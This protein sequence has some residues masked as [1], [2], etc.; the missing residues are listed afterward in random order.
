MLKSLYMRHPAY[1]R[2][3]RFLHSSPREATL[4]LL[5][6]LGQLMRQPQR[7]AWLGLWSVVI[8]ILYDRMSIIIHRIANQSYY[9][10]GLPIDGAFQLLDP[11]RRMAAGQVPGVDFQFFHGL[12]TLMIHYPLFQLFGGNLHASELS[13]EIISP[14]LFVVTAVVLVYV[15]TR[16]WLPALLGLV[17]L[18]LAYPF[19]SNLVVSSNSLL[20]VRTST[21]LL[22]GAAIMLLYQT[23]QRPRLHLA[24]KLLTQ[25]LLAAAFFM[26]IEHGVAAIV[27]YA[28]CLMLFGDG[29][30]WLRLVRAGRDLVIIAVW[31]AAIF[32]LVSGRHWFDPIKF[33]VVELPADQF[34]YF[35]APPN[36]FIFSRLALLNDRW[37]MTLW[38][39][40]GALIILLS[41]YRLSRIRSQAFG[42]IFL[43]MYG[44]IVSVA[45][46]G[47][48]NPAYIQPLLRVVMLALVAFG[49]LWYEH[50]LDR[51][52]RYF[53]LPV[54]GVSVLLLLLNIA[55]PDDLLAQPNPVDY[56]TTTTSGMKLSDKWE[57]YVD[58]LHSAV[59]AGASLWSTYVSLPEAEAG[60][61]NPSGYDY[62]IHALGPTRRAEYSQRFIANPPQFVQT[63]RHDFTRYEEWL[64]MEHWDW[65][66]WVLANYRFKA[67]SPHSVVWERSTEGALVNPNDQPWLATVDR[68]GQEMSLDALPADLPDGTI[69]T[70]E[71]EYHAY[72]L[73][74]KI[75]LVNRLPRYLVAA[76]AS[77]NDIPASLPAYRTAW[78]FPV[79]T[80]DGHIP[81]LKFY[82]ASVAPGGRFEVKHV[83]YRVM[84]LDDTNR[85]AILSRQ[86]AVLA[87]EELPFTQGL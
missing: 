26:G 24:I 34:W 17:V 60:T 79:V 1:S 64:Q 21:P 6:A 9:F 19:V 76:H 48:E 31:A 39:I 41:R 49:F 72:S 13:R 80:K 87:G 25:L 82:V 8:F 15:A 27:S 37:L 28:L 58:T 55:P 23:Y 66:Q 47:I 85:D 16:R 61:F 32:M 14:L 2:L 43:I 18:L 70:V 40:G 78:Q 65:Y 62:I 84:N 83:R 54:A 59:P 46:L 63:I 57:H 10:D 20:G 50:R 45:M 53:A 12:G 30:W 71:V 86:P 73:F 42:F 11:L 3:S 74:E 69:V 67:I 51:G 81:N 77:A 4:S 33:A 7:L 36:N 38:L 44:L 22:V 35:G 52:A 29:P 68:P 75:P 5:G 56:T